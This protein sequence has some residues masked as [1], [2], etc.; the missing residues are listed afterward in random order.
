MPLLLI[1]LLLYIGVAVHI[2][3]LI[4]G[5]HWTIEVI[6]YLVAGIAWAFPAGYLVKWMTARPAPADDEF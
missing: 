6:Y 5:I 3:G 2:G 4:Y 1:G